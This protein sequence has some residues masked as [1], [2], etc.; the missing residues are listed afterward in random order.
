MKPT[1]TPT[2]LKFAVTLSAL[3]FAFAPASGAPQLQGTSFDPSFISAGDRVNISANIRAVDY[4]D[5]NWDS[6][7]NLKATLKPGN[8]LTREYVTIEENRDQ[9]IGF[10]YPQGIWNQRYQV[11]I[12]SG[13]PTG[14]YGFEIHMQYLEDGQPVEIQTGEDSYNFTVIRKFSIP[15]DNEGVGI[16][17]NVRETSPPTPRPGDDHIQV[18]MSFTNTGNKPVEEVE[19]RPNSLES[20]KPAFSE[21]EKFFID[22]LNTGKSAEKTISLEIDEDTDPGLKTVDLETE[23][24]DISGNT[25]T[26]TVELPLRIE[27]RP[28]LELVEKERKMRAGQTQTLDLKVRNQGEQD[29]ESVTARLLAERTQPFKLED[30]SGYI[31]E[32]ES[33]EEGSAAL[34]LTADRSAS[35][36]EHNIKIQLR[37]NGDSEEGDE[38]VYTYTDQVD[39]DL[40]SRTQSPLIYLGILLAV[41]VAGFGAFRYVRR[42]DNGDTE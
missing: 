24:E 2:K 26:E 38:S 12:D 8:R 17:G 34:R 37:A 1:T 41:L 20:V 42:Y 13:A 6:E 33:G 22:R 31:G 19:I 14:S 18:S 27:G 15:V 7:K 29:A 9:S 16:S 10:L 32:I 40:T 11:K 3:L 39:I 25:Y 36:K 30:R 28:D 21:D 4:P 5:K 35:L 23:F